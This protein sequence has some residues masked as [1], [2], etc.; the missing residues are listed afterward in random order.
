MNELKVSSVHCPYCGERIEALLDCSVPV[1]TYTEDCQVCC[2]P[3]V[4]NV[5][6]VDEVPAVSVAREDD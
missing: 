5:S 6:V 1:Q 2:R 3:I 4:F